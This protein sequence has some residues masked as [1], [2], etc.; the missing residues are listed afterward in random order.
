MWLLISIII[1]IFLFIFLAQRKNT[2]DK[3]P[4]NRPQKEITPE[5]KPQDDFELWVSILEKDK[6]NAKHFQLFGTRAAILWNDSDNE[7]EVVCLNRFNSGEPEKGSKYDHFGFDLKGWYWTVYT[8]RGAADKIKEEI[9][10][11]FGNRKKTKADYFPSFK[12]DI[13]K[14]Q[15]PEIFE[16]NQLFDSMTLIWYF[17][18]KRQIRLLAPQRFTKG[19]GSQTY[20]TFYYEIQN[21]KPLIS[22]TPTGCKEQAIELIQNFYESIKDKISS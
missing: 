16:E 18:K 12:A 1:V 3:L 7:I 19:V 13:L 9:Q 22:D 6:K 17:P 2:S 20:G 11:I 14:Y 10:G 15:T 4:I 8:P 5:R 21:G